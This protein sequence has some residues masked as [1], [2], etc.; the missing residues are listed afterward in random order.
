MT[1]GGKMQAT[2]KYDVALSA[3]QDALSVKPGD[4]AATNKINEIQQIL[5]NIANADASAIKRK[6]EFDILIKKADG[7]FSGKEYL[8]AKGTYEEALAIFS[9]DTYAQMQVE[10]CIK[11]SRQKST[12]E[13]EKQYQKVIAAADKKFAEEDYDKAIMR[14]KTT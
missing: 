14:Y 2:K 1:K 4:A 7:L 5:D 13:E 9:N 3:Y 8:Q 10:E 12:A 6:N 11:L